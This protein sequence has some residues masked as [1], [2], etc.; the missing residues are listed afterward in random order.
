[1]TTEIHLRDVRESDFA[2]F[3]E[4]QREPESA[5]MAGFGTKDPDASALAARWKKSRADATTVQKAIVVGED[6]VGFV[7]SFLWQG[8]PEVTYWIAQR[9]WGRGVAT[10]ALM[11]LLEVVRV[12]PIYASAAKDNVGSLRV[13]EKCGFR[14]CGAGR[15]FAPARGE[16][17]EEVYLQLE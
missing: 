14:I 10:T 8:K 11:Q 4:L 9:H 6:V 16:E 13:L 17:I 3:F 5:R 1:V 15:D 12:R 7:A 2:V